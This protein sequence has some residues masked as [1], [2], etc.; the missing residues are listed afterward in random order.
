M[1]LFGNFMHIQLI[2]NIY[3]H[4]C[5]LRFLAQEY[6]FMVTWQQKAK[7]RLKIAFS[8]HFRPKQLIINTYHHNCALRFFG[9]KMQIHGY[10]GN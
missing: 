8:A 1:A 6:K 4:Y 9:I 2:I 10:H 5:V 3:Q 7:K